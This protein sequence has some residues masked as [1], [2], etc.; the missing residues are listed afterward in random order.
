M[1]RKHPF[2]DIVFLILLYSLQIHVIKYKIGDIDFCILS[3]K[4]RQNLSVNNMPLEEN[5]F[6]EHG[7][8]KLLNYTMCNGKCINL[9][10]IIKIVLNVKKAFKISQL[11]LDKA[12]L[13]F[14]WMDLMVF[15]IGH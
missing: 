8:S 9:L 15:L 11:L 2:I 12:T 10:I 4:I 1:L 13:I 5:L 3:R 6:F 7:T 14:C